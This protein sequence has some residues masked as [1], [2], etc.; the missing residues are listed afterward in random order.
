MP[1]TA[2]ATDASTPTVEEPKPFV[3]APAAPAPV[4][5]TTPAEQNAPDAP[6][7]QNAANV[8]QSAPVEPKNL[9]A[10][11][12]NFDATVDAKLGN[13]TP[14]E[15]ADKSF[16]GKVYDMVFHHTKA[17]NGET[18]PTQPAAVENQV[19][20]ASKQAVEAPKAE[21][22]AIEAPEGQPQK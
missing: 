20:D 8:E 18:V 1:Q 17:Q 3:D 4:E 21:T 2:L 9:D 22:P 14:E 5:P 6:V 11:K 16:F 13:A 10:A 19:A 15:K 7:T 12:A